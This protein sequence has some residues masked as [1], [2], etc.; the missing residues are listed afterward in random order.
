MPGRNRIV[1]MLDGRFFRSCNPREIHVLVGSDDET[2]VLRGF[3]NDAVAMGK[4]LRQHT[5]KFLLE[6]H[7][8]IMAS[9]KGPIREDGCEC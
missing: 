3:M 2:E 4:V 7:V 1:D 8:F 5:L 9:R 6:L